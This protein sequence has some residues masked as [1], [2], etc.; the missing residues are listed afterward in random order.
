MEIATRM[1]RKT[2]LSGLALLG[3]IALPTLSWGA[4]VTLK[5]A[6]GTVNLVGEFVDFKD[7]SYIIRTK[8][9]DLRISASRV[10]CEGEACP[11]VG[12]ATADVKITGSGTIGLGMMPLLMTGFASSMEAEAEITN[13]ANNGESIAKLVA[14]SGFGDDIG[15][16]LVRS[17]SSD[18]AF[19]ALLKNESQ[20]AMSARRILPDEARELRAAGAGN[21]VS[22]EQERIV[23]VDSVVVVTNPANKVQELTV[24]QLRSIF[25]GK[26]RNW[27]DVG[28]DDHPIQVIA[29]E[30]G[31][32]SY[33]FFMNYLFDQDVPDFRPAGLAPDDQSVSNTVYL[34]PHAIGYVGY[35]FQRGANAV[36]LVNEC[37]LHARPDAFS[38]KTEEYDLNRR[39]YLYSRSDRLDPSAKSLLDF[40]ISPEAD[41]V[42]GKSGFIDLGILRRGQTQEDERGL[43]LADE[44]KAY[45][46][47]FETTV[48]K[49]MLEKMVHYDRLSTTF[50]FRLGSSKM[51]ERG[52]L[53]MERL[54]S[55]LE[56]APE[57]TEITFVGFTDS[58][59]SFEGNRRLSQGRASEVMNE[60]RRSAGARLAHIKMRTEGFGEVSPSACNV[61]ERGRAVNRR[62]EVWINK[63]NDKA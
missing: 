39:M 36:T 2:L 21:M 30:K 46:A 20:I 42:I 18:E 49:E 53:D 9:G 45:D 28:G 60:V 24:D 50:R 8:L 37:G 1:N 57:G 4:E 61:S 6:D 23:A 34:D 14:D 54:I 22:P 48:A 19:Q 3:A 13:T 43:A 55:F 27:K 33:E 62:V 56:D 29:Q 32:T 15:S 63:Q 7:D 16:F 47:G 40:A 31:S 12:S 25:S 11:Q 52:K 35:A 10:R 51:D 58:V 38:A 59:G 17:T 41:G 26:V 5:S 44:I